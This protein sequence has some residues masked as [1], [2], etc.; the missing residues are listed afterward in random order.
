MAEIIRMPKLSDTMTEGVVAEWHKKIG[1]E[2]DDRVRVR[3]S[4]TKRT[5]DPHDRAAHVGNHRP[6]LRRHERNWKRPEPRHDEKASERTRRPS[7]ADRILDAIIAAA[8]SEEGKADKVK[9]RQRRGWPRLRLNIGHNLVQELR[10]V[11]ER[12]RARATA[13]PRGTAEATS[14]RL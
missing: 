10:V 12:A 7:G 5:L 14:S 3:N 4:W 8:H 6:E 2:V 11:C 1:D 9:R 13:R